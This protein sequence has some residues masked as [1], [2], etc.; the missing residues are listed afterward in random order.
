LNDLNQGCLLELAKSSA[1]FM[2]KIEAANGDFLEDLIKLA[3]VYESEDHVEFEAI[4][5]MYESFAEIYKSGSVHYRSCA[6]LKRVFADDEAEYKRQLGFHLDAAEAYGLEYVTDENLT[7][8]SRL[9]EG[10]LTKINNANSQA[11]TRAKDHMLSF[12]IGALRAPE[13]WTMV[14]QRKESAISADTNMKPFSAG[15]VTSNGKADNPGKASDAFSELRLKTAI[16]TTAAK[17][18]SFLCRLSRDAKKAYGEEIGLTQEQRMRKAYVTELGVKLVKVN[19]ARAQLSLPAFSLAEFEADLIKKKDGKLG[20]VNF[21]V[22]FS[23]L[24]TFL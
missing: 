2:A 23:K 19:A 14:K 13:V 18:A 20:F 24:I 5:K 11:A 22:V 9:P 15:S 10:V 21:T 6:E 4:E 8:Y 17:S 12:A 16:S 3:Q 1:G 7:G